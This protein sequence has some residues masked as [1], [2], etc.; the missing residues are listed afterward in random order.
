MKRIEKKSNKEYIDECNLIHN[1]KY[2]LSKVNYINSKTKIEI[3]CP[4]HGSFCQRP[5]SHLNGHGCNKCGCELTNKKQ[6]TNKKKLLLKLNIKHNYKYNYEK[7]KF[8]N[9]TNKVVII[10]PFHGEF[11]QILKNHING[12]ACPIC[13]ESKGEREISKIL[14]KN[15]IKYIRQYKFENC[16]NKRKLP[17]DFYLPKLN[18]CIEFDGRQHFEIVNYWNGEK[19]LKQIRKHDQIKTNYCLNNDIE[20][21]RIKYNENI[22]N[23]IKTFLENIL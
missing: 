9:I 18:I 17:F 1:Y 19:G 6:Q 16:R 22:E 2:D 12:S 15:N 20:L 4:F 13:N 23:K 11:K 8:N 10:C 14:N 7:L 21:L 5:D 3:I